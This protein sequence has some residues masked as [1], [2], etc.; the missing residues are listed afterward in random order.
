[1]E[2]FSIRDDQYHR[3]L[4]E[5][6]H[7]YKLQIEGFADTILHKVPSRGADIE[8]GTAAIRALV[9]ISR[10]VETGKW[11]QLAEMVGGV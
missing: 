3:V 8:D 6:A 9:A 7:F 4:G 1:V 11:M 10:S 2:Y 5:D